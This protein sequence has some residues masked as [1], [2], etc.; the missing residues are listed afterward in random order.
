MTRRYRYSLVSR[1]LFLALAMLALVVVGLTAAA[2]PVLA[3]DTPAVSAPRPNVVLV[4]TDDQGYGPLGRHGNPWIRTPNLDDLYDHSTRFTRYLV[5][6]TC[7]PTRSALMTGR[8]P[9]RN[10]VTHTILERER[11]TLDATT[12]PQLLGEANY[13]SAI[14]GKWHL[15]DED[16]YQPQNRGFDE[17][18]I[19]GGGGI[20]QA[21]DCSCADAPGNKYFDPV[22]RH[23][24]EFVQTHGFCTDVFFTAAL[25]W[26]D[27]VRDDEQPFFA[28]IATNAPHAPYYA[29][30]REKQRFLDLGFGDNQAGFY[31]MVENID[32]NVGRLMHA[33]DE[34]KLLDNTVVIFMSD[35]GMAHGGVAG[36]GKPLGT[37]EDG[38][39][40]MPNNDGMRGLKGNVD[41]GGVRVPL[42]V[43]WDGRYSAGRDIDQVTAH[44]DILPTLVE[45]AGGEVPREQVEGRSLV[46]LLEDASADWPDR[47]LYTHL[48][49]W[50]TGDEPNEYQWNTFAVRN[51]RFRF[52]NNTRLHD[53]LADPGQKTNVIEQYPEVAAEMRTAYDQWWQTTRPMM[54]NE[55][56]EMS[57]VRPFH[58]AF[59]EQEQTTGIPDWQPQ[60]DSPLVNP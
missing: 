13:T 24:G 48:G 43:R 19:H 42:F 37:A 52:V 15:G 56:A 8:H 26:I 36:A 44:I 51:E 33:L 54:V 41:E 29:P 25:D 49:R 18:F 59:R 9:M 22:I 45:L 2:P 38:T 12:L 32:T 21:Y 6:P 60:S 57:P 53:M 3:D 50:K 23:N 47:Y 58:D 34:W 28:Y 5:C 39:P 40:M 1:P 4:I 20:G 55:T 11:M 7:A 17:A 35:N 10:G 14:F 46:P 31:G 27:R 16:A 30:E